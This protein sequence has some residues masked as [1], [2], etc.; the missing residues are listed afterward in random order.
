MG[1]LLAELIRPEESIFIWLMWPNSKALSSFTGGIIFN[2][3][4]CANNDDDGGDDENKNNN[5]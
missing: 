5:D 4:G 2:Q 1:Y 3:R